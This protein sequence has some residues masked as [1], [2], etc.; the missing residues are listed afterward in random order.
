M[1]KEVLGA[2]SNIRYIDADKFIILV[3]QLPGKKG[4]LVVISKGQTA[5]FKDSIIRFTRTLTPQF[6][7]EI[8]SL[9]DLNEI[10]PKI[11]ALIR[12][13]FPYLHLSQLE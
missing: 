5:L 13:S 11:D 6:I 8:N 2:G 3:T 4:V 10:R 1:F 7:D 9:I 12:A